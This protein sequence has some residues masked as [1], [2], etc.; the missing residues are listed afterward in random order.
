MAL[1][2]GGCA[3]HFIYFTFVPARPTDG[4]EFERMLAT[5]PIFTTIMA[6]LLGGAPALVG[7][8]LIW[9]GL[10]MIRGPRL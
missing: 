9:R 2:C 8:L 7:F 1:L 3:F 10:R 6:L 4:Y 5:S